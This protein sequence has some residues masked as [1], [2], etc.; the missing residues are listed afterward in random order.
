[1]IIVSV[2]ATDPVLRQLIAEQQAELA[3]LPGFTG[4]PLHDGI[5]YVAAYS[6][7]HPVGCGGVQ[8]LGDGVG[9]VKRM[10]VRPAFRGQGRSRLILAA[11]EE[12]AVQRGYHTLRLETGSHLAPA[13]ALY[14]G[15]GYA[16][17]PPFGDYVG[18]DTSVCF[19]KV[20]LAAPSL[21]RP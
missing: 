6:G 11:I 21:D 19:E 4:F 9:E 7:G 17:I 3:G 10:Y 12:Y 1:M 2:A 13:L 15:A 14:R 16:H 8:P 18:N 5:T 20:L